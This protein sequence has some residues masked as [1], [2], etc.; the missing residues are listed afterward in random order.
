MLSHS[1]DYEL[2]VRQQPNEA[3]VTLPGRE[4]NR[5]PIDPPP[6][7][8][9]KVTSS[10]DP[11]KQFLQSPYLFLQCTLQ[12]EQTNS[13]DSSQAQIPA[14]QELTGQS[15]SSLHRLKD[16]NNEDGG[17]F[18]LG[19]VSVKLLGKHKLV[20]SLFELQKDSGQVVYLKSVTSDFFDVVQHK[21]WRGLQESSH[22]SR[23]FSDQ[24]VRLRLRKEQRSQA[25]YD[26][27]ASKRVGLAL[28][29]VDSVK[30]TLQYSPRSNVQA[31]PS[32]FGYDNDPNKRPRS[33][34]HAPPQ[35]YIMSER[36]PMAYDP[37]A[38]PQNMQ[39]A[40]YNLQQQQAL[41][42]SP[43]T[44]FGSRT[45]TAPSGW[46]HA[47]VFKRTNGA[48]ST[49]ARY[50]DSSANVTQA[51]APS[52][53]AAYG[54][55]PAPAIGHDPG[56]PYPRRS[57]DSYLSMAH[58]HPQTS[59]TTPY[60]GPGES[61]Y[62]PTSGSMQGPSTAYSEHDPVPMA[63]QHTQT[64]SAG[65][66]ASSTKSTLIPGA[67][68][69]PMHP[70]Q[71]PPQAYGTMTDSPQFGYN[72]YQQRLYQAPQTLLQQPSSNP[73]HVLETRPQQPSPYMP[74]SHPGLALR[75]Q[76]P[77]EPYPQ[78]QQQQYAADLGHAYQASGGAT[79][80]TTQAPDQSRPY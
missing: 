68:A 6:I 30:R 44:S 41:L 32:I 25:G 23:T 47:Q 9:L 33:N 35:G 18:V 24:G 58:Q 48:M 39:S 5:K 31:G 73:N 10:K 52:P 67:T 19:D 53:G 36:A 51:M 22:L 60:Q 27:F 13:S 21:Q 77:G 64:H 74:Q 20:F 11:G 56:P 15:C 2:V 7:I 4:K 54:L 45:P 78:P 26:L 42:Q 61:M 50:P 63:R 3:L 38:G 69:Y 71:M 12:V 28:T 62:I 70:Q 59:P 34:D 14:G 37:R 46:Q 16:I 29:S 66:P 49:S 65:S 79:Y 57:T 40:S 80:P 43:Q 8:E 17:F 72:Q 55:Q 76:Q 1:A 75:P